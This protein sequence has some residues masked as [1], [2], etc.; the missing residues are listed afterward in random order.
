MRRE[1][2][3]DIVVI[4]S[5][6]GCSQPLR[7]GRQINLAPE[8]AGFRLYRAIPAIP[9]RFENLRQVREKE[10]VHT[11]VGRQFLFE[12]E[13]ARTIP[14]FAL[15]QQFQLLPLSMKEVRARRQPLNAV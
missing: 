15:F 14:E 9:E 3:H 12:A 13:V 6:A 7:V 8:N 1:E 11:C 4:K 10:N 2:S 5:Q